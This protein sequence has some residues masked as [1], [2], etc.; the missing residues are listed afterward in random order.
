MQLSTLKLTQLQAGNVADQLEGVKQ[1]L[2]MELGPLRS[3]MEAAGQHRC[4]AFN[5][6]NVTTNNVMGTA[7]GAHYA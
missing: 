3:K 5:S 2:T 7:P 4:L 1:E 6:V